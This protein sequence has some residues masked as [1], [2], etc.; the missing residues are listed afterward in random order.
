MEATQEAQTIQERIE[1]KLDAPVEENTNLSEETTT[2]E[3]EAE[4][5]DVDDVETEETE[6]ESEEDDTDDDQD[7]PDEDGESVELSDIAALLGLDESQLDIDEE[8]KII[9]KTKI[10]GQEGTAKLADLIKSHQLEGH[11]NKQN[12]E[13][14]EQRKRLEQQ[15]QQFQEEANAKLKQLGDSLS[16]A[17]NQ[18]NY[19]FQNVD[20]NSLKQTDPAQYSVLRQEFEDRQAQINY[21][22][23]NLEQ[24]KLT[25]REQMR[26]QG[27]KNLL[28][29]IPE[30]QD[31]EAREKGR[32]EL[33]NGL[34]KHY[35]YSEKELALAI[36][37]GM[38]FSGLDHRLYLM[39]RDAL[40]YR[41][42]QDKKP[43]ITKKVNK[44]VKTVK[45]RSPQNQDSKSL[46]LKNTRKTIKTSGGKKGVADYLMQKGIV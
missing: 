7:A 38:D 4:E 42:L 36:D 45:A 33:K 18:L 29:A 46:Q 19:E 3:T 20:W 11:L 21:A 9:A 13:V 8:G 32:I 26:E 27:V 12:M 5:V 6:S 44:S 16:L 34:S 2:E 23:Q 43:E 30:W 37:Q 35:G 15:Q 24:N 22:Y 10:D 1:A 25:Q 31:A 40:K 39:A 14:V 41:E 17:F 28:N